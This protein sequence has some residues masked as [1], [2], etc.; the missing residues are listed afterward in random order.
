MNS[1]SESRLNEEKNIAEAVFRYQLQT[2]H[3]FRNSKSYFLALEQC[4]DPSDEFMQRFADNDKV[5]RHS[6]SVFQALE[7]FDKET[8]E[9]G[10]ILQV[11]AIKWI[12]DKEVE[13]SG[14]YYWGEIQI[15]TYHLQQKNSHWVVTASE[16]TAIS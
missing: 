6:Q 12:N 14:S 8:G 13:A 11:R 9:P 15:F 2:S 4:T 5:K 3:P 1:T 10:L 7:V 16:C